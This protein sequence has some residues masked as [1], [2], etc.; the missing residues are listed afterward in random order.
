MG[1]ACH[2]HTPSPAMPLSDRYAKPA[3]SVA[4]TTLA[5][6]VNVQRGDLSSAEPL[7]PGVRAPAAAITEATWGRKSRNEAKLI[8]N[9]GGMMAGS[10]V[11]DCCNLRAEL[12]IATR[13]RTDSC[14]VGR[15][16][17][18][19]A[20]G[21]RRTAAAKMAAAASTPER[22]GFGIEATNALKSTPRPT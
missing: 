17:S 1:N 14:S 15:D 16:C 10:F 4:T 19:P 7:T 5:T 20:S 13:I 6:S 21:A 22:Q 11:V 12:R 18:P 2:G 8:R 3:N 9:D